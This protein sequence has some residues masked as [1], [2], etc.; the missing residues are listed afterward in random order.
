MMPFHVYIIQS[1]QDS[2]YYTGSTQELS[3][4]LKRHN[5]GRSPY[6]KAKRPWKLVYS[7]EFADRSS[8]QQRERAIKRKKSRDYIENLVSASRS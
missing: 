7:E 2:S 1:L 8:A 5:Q 3:S 6:T 4:R